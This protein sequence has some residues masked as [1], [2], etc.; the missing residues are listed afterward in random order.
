MKTNNKQNIRQQLD[1]GAVLHAAKVGS[2]RAVRMH[3]L[4]GNPVATVKNG[5]VVLIPPEQI[6]V[7]ESFTTLHNADEN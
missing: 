2:R 5:K 7:D 1:D 3:K 4:L 6:L